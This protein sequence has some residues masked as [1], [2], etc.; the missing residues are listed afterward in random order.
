MND[1]N[2]PTARGEDSI[3]VLFPQ[4]HLQWI[5]DDPIMQHSDSSSLSSFK[6]FFLQRS[7][8]RLQ[9]FDRRWNATYM[10]LISHV[11]SGGGHDG[12]G[13]EYG[14]GGSGDG[15]GGGGGGGEGDGGGGGGCKLPQQHCSNT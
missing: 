1:S 14:G 13:G 3:G 11:F 12:H 9:S 7:T 8:Q 6:H 4:Q 15:G 2:L 5:E 10:F